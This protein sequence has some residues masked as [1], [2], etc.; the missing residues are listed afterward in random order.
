MSENSP[1]MEDIRE[2]NDSASACGAGR[3]A[4]A[5]VLK[6]LKQYRKLCLLFLAFVIVATIITPP[7]A[8]SQLVA[9]VMMAIVYGLTTLTMSRFKLLADTAPLTKTVLI[10]VFSAA[11][12]LLVIYVF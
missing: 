7:D 9:A 12:T 8:I 3:Y 1:P 2:T 6:I 11:L 10:F 4:E 5:R